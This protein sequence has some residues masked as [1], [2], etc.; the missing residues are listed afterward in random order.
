MNDKEIGKLWE[1]GRHG[2]HKVHYSSCPEVGCQDDHCDVC[3]LIRKL[4][5]ERTFSYLGRIKLEEARRIALG[6]FGIDPAT[7]KEEP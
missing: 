7:W 1:K 3:A 5:K 6:N 4:V 2:K